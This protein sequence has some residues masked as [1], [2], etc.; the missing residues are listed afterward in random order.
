MNHHSTTQGAIYEASTP[1]VHVTDL[2]VTHPAVTSEALRWS[3]GCRGTAISA[4]ALDGADLTAYIEQALAVGAQAISVAGGTQDTY[5]LEQL[6]QDVGTRT[7]ESTRAAT[8]RTGEVVTQATKA[9]QQASAE[10]KKVLSEAGEQAR[11]AFGTSVSTAQTEL[12][13]Q[14]THLLGGQD[15]ELVA[16][17]R[18]LLQD[19]AG[20]LTKQ[21][22]E[23]TTAL[24]DKATRALNP[25]DPT[26]PMAKHLVVLDRQHKALTS[27][28]QEQHSALADK[29]GELTRAVQ[30]QKAAGDATKR[31][32]SVT[33]LKGFTYEDSVG[34]VLRDIA[35]GL[36][37]E[38]AD[39]G[40]F[41]GLLSRCKKGDGV[42]TV[43]GGSTKV[44]MEMSDSP[45]STWSDYLDEAERNR[46]ACAALGI[47]PTTERNDGQLVRVIGPRRIVLAFDPDQDDASLLRTV[48]ILLRT[49][50]LA[51]T[52]RINDSGVHTATERIAEALAALPRVETIRKTADSI[53]K[54]AQKVDTEAEKLH[55]SLDRLLRQAQTSLQLAQE[56]DSAVHLTSAPI[57]DSA[58]AA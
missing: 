46:G 25:D 38:Y 12:R 41:A 42:L 55:A 54:G 3:S 56:E 33:T 52:L 34:R 44:V 14:L 22:D 6:V 13:D 47:V 7:T 31:T 24:F 15:P 36:G 19:F 1:A 50:A 4:S 5:H 18:P 48:V 30:V 39:T 2:Q 57:R 43:G 16:R 37:D 20:R 17:L 9:M 32:A 10:A 26:S 23:H 58:G 28:V 49:A 51:A 21:A 40:A 29:I 27:T 53:R 35:I 11:T 8:E 45:R